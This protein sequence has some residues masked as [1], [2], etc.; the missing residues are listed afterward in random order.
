[1]ATI[2]P[3]PRAAQPIPGDIATLQLEWLDHLRARGKTAN[4]LLAYN[5][6]LNH[7]RAALLLLDIT[8]V[9]LVSELMINRWLDDGVLHLG[10][11]RRT[12]SRKASSVRGFFNWVEAAGYIRHNPSSDVRI[13][14]RPRRVIA[15]EMDALVPVIE[16]IGKTAPVDLRDRAMLML[17]LDAALRAGE[18]VGLDVPDRPRP[19][20]RTP[21]YTVQVNSQRVHVR[22]K[23]DSDGDVETVGIEPQTATAVR[24][25]LGVRPAV[26][27]EGEHALFVNSRGTRVSRHLLYTIVRRRGAAVGMPELHPHLFR[28]RRVGEVVEKL[29]LDVGSALA[30]HRCKA[31]TVNVYGAHAAEVQ[32]QSVR[33]GAALPEVRA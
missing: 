22:P 12:A 25:W 28:H 33:T 26:A 11:S 30:R 24:A 27:K 15:P 6:D 32:R 31:T 23:G 10:W 20:A 8:L 9:Q 16:A 17:L 1:M 5:A 29:G 2:T 19:N 18:V 7:F 3:F 14:F 21:L 13:K 4:T